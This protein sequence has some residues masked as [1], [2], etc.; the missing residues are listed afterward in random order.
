MELVYLPEKVFVDARAYPG[1]IRGKSNEKQIMWLY[2]T[3]LLELISE[4]CPLNPHFGEPLFADFVVWQTEV[5]RV[6]TRPSD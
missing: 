1:P 5:V 6:E 4:V 2:R 3:Q